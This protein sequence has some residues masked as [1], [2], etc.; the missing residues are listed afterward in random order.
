[1]DKLV[2][3]STDS[4]DSW[5]LIKYVKNFRRLDFNF[6]GR[7]ASVVAFG[8][9][10]YTNHSQKNQRINTIVD[11]LLHHGV[12]HIIGF[13][14]DN[15]LAASDE[16]VLLINKP[17]KDHISASEK[18]IY[19][20]YCVID[21]HL[22]FSIDQF[23]YLL[24]SAWASAGNYVLGVHCQAGMGRTG[25]AL[26][27]FKILEQYLTNLNFFNMTKEEIVLSCRA[28][29]SQKH[30]R[31][32][33][34]TPDQLEGLYTL[35]EKLQTFII[36]ESFLR[37]I[38]SPVGESHQV[39]HTHSSWSQREMDAPGRL[40]HSIAQR[41]LFDSREDLILEVNPFS[42]GAYLHIP[43][44]D[45]VGPTIARDFE[46]DPALASTSQSFQTNPKPIENENTVNCCECIMNCAR[47]FI[48][49]R[50]AQQVTA[51]IDISKSD[52]SITAQVTP[53][54]GPNKLKK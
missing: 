2:A 15:C 16:K 1:M 29:F 53:L 32:I 36:I 19:D 51:P 33:D 47:C 24:A 41:N 9:T 10:D 46:S 7:I 27:A 39:H 12:K 45:V 25:T 38:N 26:L 30:Q 23:R 54:A 11:G 6:D 14:I 50:S 34:I 5:P 37:W 21:N 52:G 20:S 3:A 17:S 44:Q 48:F 49:F 28:D 18:I 4:S 31:M 42:R 8:F 13:E 35:I 40:T 43:P 22:A